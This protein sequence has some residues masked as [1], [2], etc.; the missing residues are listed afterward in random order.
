MLAGRFRSAATGSW[1]TNTTWQMSANGGGTWAAATRVP[2]SLA[3][4]TV[5]VQNAHTITLNTSPANPLATLTIGTGTSGILTIG[6]NTTVRTISVNG[7][8]TVS[9]GGRVQIPNSTVTHQLNIGGNLIVNGIFDLARDANSLCNATFN[10]AGSQTISGTGTTTEFNTITVSAVNVV[11]ARNLSVVGN[12]AL[13]AGIFDLNNFTA[14]RTV[15]GGSA[16][17]G[18][19]TTLRIAGTNSLPI[20]YTTFT[21]DASSTVEYYGTAQTINAVTYGNLIITGSGTKSTPTGTTTTIV[22]GDFT[23]GIGNVYEQAV[24]AVSTI[25]MN[26]TTNTNDGTLGSISNPFNTITVGNDAGDVLVNNNS[27]NV[28]TDLSGTGTLTQGTN[29]TLNIGGTSTIAVLNA[30]ATGNTIEYDGTGAQTI[31]AV[32]YYNLTISGARTINNVTLSNTGVIGIAGTF[33][34]SASFTSGEYIMTGSTI[35][36]NGSGMQTVPSFRYHH[37]Q[38]STGGTK[39]A[40]GNLQIYGT[41]TIGMSSSFDAA[42]TIDT[43]YGD[44]INNGTFFTSGSIIVFAG[45]TPA[46][47]SGVTTFTT[48][49]ANKSAQ[50]TSITLND[51][52]SAGTLVMT[53]GTINTGLNSITMTSART[54]NGIIFGTITRTHTFSANASYEF[55]G[56]YNTINFDNT[57][58]LPSSVTIRVVADSTSITNTYMNPI[59]RYYAISQSGGFGYQYK[60]RLHYLDTEF[61]SPNSETSPPLKVW[62]ESA[63]G[64]WNRLGAHSNDPTNNWVQWD[65]VTTMGQ[66]SLSSRTV[67]NVVLSLA[68]DVTNPGPNDQATYTVSYNNTGDGD[69]TNVLFVA[70]IPTN[71]TYVP[72]SIIVNGTPKPDATSGITINPS[73]ISINLSTLLGSPVVPGASGTIV[74]KVVF[75]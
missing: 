37:L 71:T 43:I 11:L 60:L 58:V 65:S 74:Y 8:I 56:P 59:N 35:N 52:V 50:N 1:A 21:I 57:G 7:D 46:A 40:G 75:N 38:T 2:G 54:G 66:F 49:V 32:N 19:N 47:I 48:L 39:T 5:L 73:A 51:N 15:A 44:W 70:P 12:M 14:N 62:F 55:E 29:S 61:A 16:T 13:T 25:T 42:S 26:G 31:R 45:S 28:S 41:L 18:A 34:A 23:L 17:V 20:N 10:G 24:G 53:T 33:S 9:A 36:F 30:T 4:D 27:I 68:A 22:T 6:N 72:E 69:A 64:V 63:P 3:N 67:A